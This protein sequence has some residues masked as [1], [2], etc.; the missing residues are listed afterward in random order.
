VTVV[1]LCH[2]PVEI[3]SIANP[4]WCKKRLRWW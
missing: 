3:C 4:S 2:I 1:N